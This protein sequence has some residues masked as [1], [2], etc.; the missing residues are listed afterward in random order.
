MGYI[1][2]IFIGI[3][4]FLIV[5]LLTFILEEKMGIFS[6]LALILMINYPIILDKIL[7]RFFNN[8]LLL[9]QFLK[10]LHLILLFIIILSLGGVISEKKVFKP[11]FLPVYSLIL[12]IVFSIKKRMFF[13]KQALS[14]KD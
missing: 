8:K 9:Y 12:A 1:K 5:F 11:E 10:K 14:N 6:L 7:N 13:K 4:C 2:R 3:A